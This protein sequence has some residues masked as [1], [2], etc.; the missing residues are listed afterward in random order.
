[1]HRQAQIREN[2]EL[3]A[4]IFQAIRA[5][6]LDRGYLEVDTPIRVP[7]QAPEEHIDAEPSGNWFLQT[8]PELC[9]KRLLASGYSRLFQLCRCFRKAERGRRHLPEFTLLEW[10]TA[11]DDYAAMM[12][13]T[14]KLIVSISR[15]V[16]GGQSIEYLGQT[17]D[18]RPPWERLPVRDAFERYAGADADR[19]VEENRFDQWMVDRIEPNLP[20]NRPVFLVDYPAA[21]GALARLKPDDPAV[22]ERFELYIGGLELCN[23]FTELIDP[24]EQ[25]T[26]FIT[27]LGQQRKAGKIVYPMPEK[28]LAALE[29][30]PPAAGNALG[31][32]RL[33]MLFAGAPDIDGVTAFVPEEL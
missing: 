22:A 15:S 25:K 11:G 18:L 31:V 29:H 20:K 6:F 32:D 3:R 9:M 28:F 16:A 13:Q 17:I 26:R 4:R 10:Y 7:T 23:A 8:S 14:E 19:A 5:F 33:V 1:M 12:K 21:L 24:V 30:M 2:L 27:A